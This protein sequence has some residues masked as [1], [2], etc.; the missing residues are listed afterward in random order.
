MRKLWILAKRSLLSTFRDKSALIMMLVTPFVLTVIIGAAFGTG[1]STALTDVPLLIVDH[2]QSSLSQ[3]LTQSFDAPALNGMFVTTV[4]TDEIA[5]REQVDKNKAAA[6]LVIPAGF[7]ER[8][9]PFLSLVKQQMGLDL[10]TMSAEDIKALPLKQQEALGQLYEQASTSPPPPVQI[11][12]YG[13][14]M[15]PISVTTIKGITQG[16]LE[17]MNMLI[18]GTAAIAHRLITAQTAQ[19]E[20]PTGNDFAPPEVEANQPL[21][22]RVRVVV[23]EGL[24]F[25]WFDYSA[26]SMAVFFLMFTVTSGG[27][28]LLTERE[29]GTLPRL[30]ISPTSTLVILLGEMGG[31][32][33]VG[34]AQMLI[35]WGATTLIGAHWGN[36]WQVLLTIIALVFC[37][38]GV[39]A[40]ITAWSRTP[41]QVG[42]LGTAI[43]LIGG[44][45][46]GSFFPRAYL[47]AWVQKLSLIT[48][49]AWGIELFSRLHSGVSLSALLPWLAG[50]LGVTAVYYAVA[51]L[52]FRRQFD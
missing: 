15:W 6:L 8:M 22:I 30:L 47:P 51:I 37:A 45:F 3:E 43:S 40:L 16:V 1:G 32:L 21:P 11:E 14:Q 4:M 2:D 5:A 35:L 7:K 18:Q 34:L 10:A 52:G 36:P 41:R 27:R 19:G 13:G 25:S 26:A 39:G 20:A 12:I 28:S 24:T 29:N 50:M 38:T 48:P 42:A 31:V 23:P 44:G 33:L 9:F 17:R 46:S 49:N